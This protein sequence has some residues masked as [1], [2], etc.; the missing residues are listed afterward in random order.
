MTF[1]E[2]Y[3]E[4]LH[5]ELGSED[6]TELF[7]TVRRKAAINRACVEFA[8]LTQCFV[9][10][11]VQPV[12]LAVAAYDLD[13]LTTD[14]FVNFLARPLR[15]QRTTVAT[16]SISETR[17]TRRDVPWLDRERDGWR[18]SPQTGVPDVWAFVAD[19][20]T[21]QVVLSP[22]PAVPADETWA[23]IVPL[24]L[25]PPVMGNDNDV[26]FTWLGTPQMALEPYHWALAH[27]A[28]SQLER[29]RKDPQA[30]ESQLAMFGAYVQDWKATRRPRGGDVRAL[31]ARDYLRRTRT[32]GTGAL[33]QGDPRV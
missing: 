26:P 21:N 15:L 25:N 23:L 2:L 9:A 22:R 16:G 11:V 28:A 13:T 19:G 31:Q 10:D 30:L 27:Y 33:A 3:G 7:T 8:R 12:T 6:V 17:L 24:V 20:G 5:H 1:A 4:A 32:S 29:L 18:N 14:L